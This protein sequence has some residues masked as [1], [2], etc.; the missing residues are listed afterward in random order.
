MPKFTDA[1]E[2]VSV[3]GVVPVPDRGIA[4]FGLDALLVTPIEPV[5]PPVTV[6]AKVTVNF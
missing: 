4:K 2:G 6:G 3:P 1:G 5:A